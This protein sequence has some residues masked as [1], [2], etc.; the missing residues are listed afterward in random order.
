MCKQQTPKYK[1]YQYNRPRTFC[2]IKCRSLWCKE[3]N[4][5]KGD[6]NASW[7]GN[8]VGYVALHDWIKRYYGK[9]SKC[10]SKTCT[11]ISNK[12]EWAN[13]SGKYLRDKSDYLMLCKSC[14]TKFDN[15]KLRGNFCQRGHELIEDNLYYREDGRRRCR[16]CRNI[17]ALLLQR[18]RRKTY[19]V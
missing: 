2:S 7:K 13:I 19:E 17:K 1:N 12:F 6:N 18:K 3:N 5:Y 16:I 4:I 10:E 14:H 8:E 15:Q 11:G 9:A